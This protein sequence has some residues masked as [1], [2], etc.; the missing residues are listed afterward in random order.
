MA[1][2]VVARETRETRHLDG[3]QVRMGLSRSETDGFVDEH[4]VLVR[5]VDVA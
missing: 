4:F 1:V 3:Q 5:H 2:G